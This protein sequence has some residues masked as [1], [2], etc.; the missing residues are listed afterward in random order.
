[1]L[2]YQN[3][4]FSE[5]SEGPFRAAAGRGA[6]GAAGGCGR[7]QRSAEGPLRGREGRGGAAAGEGTAQSNISQQ[8]KLSKQRTLSLRETPASIHLAQVGSRSCLKLGSE[9]LDRCRQE[10]SKDVKTF[11]GFLNPGFTLNCAAL[12][13]F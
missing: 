1:M 3:A 12:L 13:L 7:P 9:C 2:L 5:V 10:R 8:K 11:V 6:A 4:Y